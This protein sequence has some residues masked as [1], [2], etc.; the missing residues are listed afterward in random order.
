M[1]IRM[2]CQVFKGGILTACK[3]NHLSQ[4]KSVVSTRDYEGGDPGKIA[5]KITHKDANRKKNVD[6]EDIREINSMNASGQSRTDRI[7]SREFIDDNQEETPSDGESESEETESRDGDRDAF[8]QRKE[9][10]TI[11]YYKLP[12]GKARDQYTD[13]TVNNVKIVVAVCVDLN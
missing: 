9:E 12:K 13:W 6:I 3:Y 11:D 10:K 2:G 4:V 7:V 5:A 1:A 8:S